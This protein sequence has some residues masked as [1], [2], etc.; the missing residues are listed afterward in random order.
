MKA[1]SL[2]TTIKEKHKALEF[3]MCVNNRA[4]N[5]LPCLPVI[6]SSSSSSPLPSSALHPKNSTHYSQHSSQEDSLKTKD[7]ILALLCSSPKIFSIFS[8][9]KSQVLSGPHFVSNLISYPSPPRSLGSYHKCSSNIP[10]MLPSRVLCT[11]D[12]GDLAPLHVFSM[13]PFQGALPQLSI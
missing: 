6:A 13:L 7:Q 3:L 9:T 12:F 1:G 11:D 10:R 2:A 4:T 8:Q 5:Q